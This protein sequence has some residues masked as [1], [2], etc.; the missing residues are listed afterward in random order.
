VVHI[1]LWLTSWF[2]C[3]CERRYLTNGYFSNII[4]S[5]NK[6]TLIIIVIIIISDIYYNP[7]KPVQHV[8][9]PSWDHHQGHLWEYFQL[10]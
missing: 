3:L 7:C 9:I 5:T 2:L 8:S 1:W 10:L 4:Y 6:C